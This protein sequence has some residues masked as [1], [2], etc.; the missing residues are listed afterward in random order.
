M[1]PLYIGGAKRLNDYSYRHMPLPPRSLTRA[2]RGTFHTGKY[3]REALIKTLRWR[4]WHWLWLLSLIRE[5][6]ECHA[7]SSPPH[8]WSTALLTPRPC[9][10]QRERWIARGQDAIPMPGNA[11]LAAD[12]GSSLRWRGR[13][14]RVGRVASWNDYLFVEP[15]HA[16]PPTK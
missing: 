8:R 10:E 9:R 6:V 13:L 12:L 15:D 16:T 11:T 4:V 1:P 2:D 5:R 7:N 3:W 14:P